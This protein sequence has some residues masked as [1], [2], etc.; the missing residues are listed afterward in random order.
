M[1]PEFES[2]CSLFEKYGLTLSREVYEKLDIYAEF[3]V[4]YNENVNLTAI[5]APEEILVKHFADSVL[6]SKYADIPMNAALIDVGTGAGFPSVPLK[7][8]R[9]DIKLTLLDSLNKRIVFLQ[10]LCDKLGIGAEFI[11]ERAEIAGKMPEYREKFDVSCARAVANM[12]L[13]S[14]Y[15]IPFVKPVGIFAAMKGPSEDIS[16]AENAVRLLGGEFS[17][18][19]TYELEGEQRKIVIVKK[20]SQTPTKYPRNS[21]QIKKRS[22]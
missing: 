15:C 5:T 16:S 22:L 2:S 12:S 20:I 14:E 7:I 8:F 4:E 10:Q 6:L 3:L 21:S 19:K 11:H 9:P 13:L 17:C 18:E 1:L